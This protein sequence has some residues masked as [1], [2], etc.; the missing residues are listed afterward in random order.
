M[1]GEPRWRNGIVTVLALI[2]ST[3]VGG[4]GGATLTGDSDASTP[5]DA[6]GND[7]AASPGTG[8]SD[9]EGGNEAGSS[10]LVPCNDGTGNLD[11]CPP[12][13]VAG[14][15]CDVDVTCQTACAG[16]FRGDRF[17]SGGV[18]GAGHGLFPCGDAGN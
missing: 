2:A 3:A 15:P 5:R 4:C 8:G 13:A 7:A 6:D 16:G 10:I 12:E 17:C 11:C 9:G 18:W 1:S 14:G